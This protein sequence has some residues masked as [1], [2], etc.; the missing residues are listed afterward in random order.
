MEY[1]T[2]EQHSIPQALPTDE[3]LEIVDEYRTVLE[4]YASELLTDLILGRKSLDDLDKYIAEMEG[5]G[6]NEY[7]DMVAARYNRAIGA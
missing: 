6:L 7:C 4:T 2:W 1:G 5:L 3:E